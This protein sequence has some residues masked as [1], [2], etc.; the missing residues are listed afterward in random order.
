MLS[1]LISTHNEHLHDNNI[2]LN[3]PNYLFLEFSESSYQKN[4]LGTQKEF[5]SGTEK[6]SKKAQPIRI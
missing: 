6:F 5:E 2:F 1:V 3:I 4:F